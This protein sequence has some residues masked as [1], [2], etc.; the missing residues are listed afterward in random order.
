MDLQEALA[1]RLR[2]AAAA[3]EAWSRAVT[4]TTEKLGSGVARAIGVE[5][6]RGSIDA[7]Y[8]A[9]ER[10]I[11]KPTLIIA[12]TGTTSGGKSALLNLLCGERWLPSATLEMSAGVVTVEH[13]PTR[14]S[15]RVEATAGAFWETGEWELGPEGTRKRLRAVMDCYRDHRERPG[16]EAPR[17]LLRCPTRLGE[18]YKS[19]GLPH[20]SRVILL[21]LPGL[22]HVGDEQNSEV[23][24]KQ[25]RQA[26]CLVTYNSA[27][28]DRKLA[29]AALEEVVRQV[30]ELGG[31]P[32]RM[33]FIANRIDVFLND[34]DPETER[35]RFVERLTT[36][37]RRRVA[38]ELPERAEEA[39]ELAVIPLS[40][41]PALFANLISNSDKEV[42]DDALKVLEKRYQ[43]LIPRSLLTTMPRD[44][45]DA[46]S[47]QRD[48]LAQAILRSS[49]GIDFE[50]RLREHIANN[51]PDLILPALMAGVHDALAVSLK[52]LDVE[53]RA[54]KASAQG[55]FEQ[56][57]QRLASASDRLG[58]LRT[59]LVERCAPLTNGAIARSADPVLELAL[60]ATEVEKR[61]SL[62]KNSL[63]PLHAWREALKGAAVEDIAA[64]SKAVMRRGEVDARMFPR[65]SQAQRDALSSALLGLCRYGY[66]GKQLTV[67]RKGPKG[68][69]EIGAILT[70]L[71]AVAQALKPIIHA[72][73]DAVAHRESE[74]IVSALGVLLQAQMDAIASGA[75]TAAPELRGLHLPPATVDRVDEVLRWNISF[76]IEGETERAERYEKTG[77][78]LVH[79]AERQ[80]YTLWLW[81]KEWTEV[82][83]VWGN[84]DY[85]SMTLPKSDDLCQDLVA[86]FFN[87]APERHF[88]QWLQR[89]LE[90]FHRR[91]K[92]F[93]GECVA[94]YQAA[95]D[96]VRGEACDVRDDRVATLD[97]LLQSVG[98]AVDTASRLG[99]ST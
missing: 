7:A 53:L 40:T 22:N 98:E 92:T 45:T 8:H 97:Q 14:S 52:K 10:A 72:T 68:R 95:L 51:L 84:V 41:E 58:M 18:S 66:E 91:V 42:R 96:R 79:K 23:I 74:R 35:S 9:L 87:S 33:L 57:T 70:S 65:V 56:E 28:P 20:G 39:S 78:K 2:D 75:R 27:E 25:I 77:E 82:H 54:R 50:S 94:E 46:S 19:F 85:H 31:S 11:E 12:T 62:R 16:I 83:D 6:A 89:Q 60:A 80:W 88:L 67:E 93:Q 21:D 55:H 73:L 37:I 24:R 30:K 13:E 99:A 32:A 44:I 4:E 61:N 29:A 17:F 76:V 59:D 64:L 5:E 3:R 63:S 36:D 71:K 43:A 38:E 69:E 49:H 47:K 48:E 90:A 1:A 15:L 34:E 26:L 86:Q 81:N